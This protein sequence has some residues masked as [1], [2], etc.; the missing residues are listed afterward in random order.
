MAELNL[1]ANISIEFPDGKDKLMHFLITIRPDEGIY[2]CEHWD[3]L[4]AC[5]ATGSPATSGEQH[6]C[7]SRFSPAC[8]AC[9]VQGRQVCVRLHHLRFL[10]P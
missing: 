5:T 4:H 7:R 8:C 3:H 2:K 10:P 1:P 6:R 9:C